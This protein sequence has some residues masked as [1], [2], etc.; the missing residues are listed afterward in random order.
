VTAAAGTQNALLR[1]VSSAMFWNSAM[2]PAIMA[3]NLGAAV[4]I[5]RGFGLESGVIDI[6]LGLLN[7]LFT[8]A[9]LGVPLTIGQFVPTLEKTAGRSG[10]RAFLVGVARRRAAL[11]VAVLVPLNLLADP[12]AAYLGL[13]D[14]GPWLVHLVS[15]FAVVRASSDLAIKTLQALIAHVK[16]NVMQFVQAFV[17][18]GVVAATLATG[19]SIPDLFTLLVAAS[20]PVSACAV[21]L[22]WRTTRSIDSQPAAAASDVPSST[23]W[24]FA[25]FMYTFE[26]S[27]YFATPAFASIALAVASTGLA[28]VATFNVGFQVP[29]MI[30]TVLLAGF[31]GLYRPLFSGVMA[32]ASPERLRTAFTEISKIQAVLLVPAGI[33]LALMGPDYIHLVFGSQFAGAAPFARVFT[34]LLFAEALFNLGSIVLSVDRR[35]ATTMGAQTLRLTG[36]A[37]FVWLAIEGHM[38]VA[39][40]VFGMGR[41]LAAVVG[42]RAARRLY[43]VRFP[44]AFAARR[45]RR[46]PPPAA[47]VG[48]GRHSDARR[49]GPDHLG[50][51]AVPRRGRARGRPSPEVGPPGSGPYRGL[52]RPKLIEPLSNEQGAASGRAHRDV[53]ARTRR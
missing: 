41:V 37:A 38:I 34:V 3:V 45:G 17:F 36:A 18:V 9:A 35:Y 15:A 7:T 42:Y 53:H 11:L 39:A 31:Q 48:L 8:H 13:G 14:D 44:W 16:A 27:N 50:R 33:G 21:W 5:R 30:V 51:P 52:A 40:V 10:V 29:M 6:A 2:L 26:A 1:R 32:E 23:V 24:G 22:A 12:V 43:D 25:L 20:V 28:A 19:G 47:D 46:S 49:R 4:M